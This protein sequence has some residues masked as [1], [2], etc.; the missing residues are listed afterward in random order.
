MSIMP[1]TEAMGTSS[2]PLLVAFFILVGA[3]YTLNIDSNG[4]FD[5]K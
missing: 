3:H 1:F 4:D 2:I 5:G